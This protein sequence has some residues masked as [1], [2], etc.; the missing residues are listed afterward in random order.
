MKVDAEPSTAVQPPSMP[1]RAR[2]SRKPRGRSGAFAT[3][4]RGAISRVAV[5]PALAIVVLLLRIGLVRGGVLYGSGPILALDGLV[6]ASL[7]AAV[8]IYALR[9]RQQ[10]KS[11]TLG[12]ADLLAAVVAGL[13][14]PAATISA[15]QLVAPAQP[16]DLKVDACP[17]SQIYGLSFRA[18]TIG[19]IGNN[20]RPGPGTG[21]AEIGRLPKECTIGASGYCVGDP[22]PDPLNPEKWVD[23]RWARL[24]R[25]ES[26]PWN[27][28]A[29][30]LSH[31][32]SEDRFV[33]M[34]P[35]QP[36]SAYRDLPYLEGDC[37]SGNPLP[38]PA[39]VAADLA[40]PGE[41][42]L[43]AQADHAYNLG[44]ALWVMDEH[45]LR[46]GSR[47]RQIGAG[48]AN[49]GGAGNATWHISPLLADLKP[50]RTS[51]SIVAVAAIACLGPQAPAGRSAVSILYFAITPS[52]EVKR[53]DNKAGSL[54]DN[55]A[56]E[57]VNKACF[58]DGPGLTVA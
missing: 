33:S 3:G 6:A 27:L 25:H 14:I 39:T 56:D 34:S 42:H 51:T 36:D 22:V 52:N 54:A 15:I 46:S 17:S 32:P 47:L 21:Y 31:E 2:P 44:F 16:P 24:G 50:D 40:V 49:P 23:T 55:A 57:L 58:T 19:E 11:E 41:V 45:Q 8:C 43:H 4:A 1:A 29:Q 13:T 53:L 26:F 48:T 30:W 18:T 9:Y 37:P 35:L 38:G 7:A 10:R 5:L 28:V 20:V 12:L